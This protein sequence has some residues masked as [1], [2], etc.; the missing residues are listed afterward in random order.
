MC[1]P[2]GSIYAVGVISIY[3]MRFQSLKSRAR[4]CCVQAMNANCAVQV[5]SFFRNGMLSAR[6]RLGS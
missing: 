5:R 1:P 2:A 4:C 6:Y 3:P